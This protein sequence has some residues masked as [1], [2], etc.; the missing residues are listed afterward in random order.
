MARALSGEPAQRRSRA[1]A[2]PSRWRRSA[3][4]ARPA[5]AASSPMS[6]RPARGTCRAIRIMFQ[7]Q[8][9]GSPNPANGA[10][11]YDGWGFPPTQSYKYM[12]GTSMAAP[13]VA[14]GAAVVRDFYQK[15]RGHQASAALVKAVLDQLRRRSARREQR[16][17]S[18]QLRIRFPTFTKAGAASISSTRPMPATVLRREPPRSR[19]ATPRRT[20]SRSPRPARR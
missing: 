5:T 9:D 7:Q 16:R 12:G 2:T 11:Q 20:A 6:S 19:P 13:L 1:P 8:Y 14:G 18:R 17:R 15:S 4:A 3:A 10:Y